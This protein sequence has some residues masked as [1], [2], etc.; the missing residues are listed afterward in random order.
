MSLKHFEVSSRQWCFYEHYTRSARTHFTVIDP[1]H[2][3]P[4]GTLWSY[5]IIEGNSFLQDGYIYIKA[6]NFTELLS[7][8]NSTNVFRKVTLPILRNW[9]LQ[10]RLSIRYTAILDFKI[11]LLHINTCWHTKQREQ[12][13]LHLYRIEHG[14]TSW[15]GLN[16]SCRY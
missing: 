16:I 13:T 15:R 10:Y 3:S 14:F 9:K 8:I 6:L 1:Y 4:W 5:D 7:I 12:Q 11:L 2:I